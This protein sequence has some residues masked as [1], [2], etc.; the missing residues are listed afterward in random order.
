MENLSIVGASDGHII[1]VSSDGE[2]FQVP[3]N[4][5]LLGALRAPSPGPGVTHR[6]SP[7]DIQAHIRRGLT[8]RQVADLTGEE[9]PYIEKFEGPV[10]AERQFVVDQA[11]AVTVTQKNGPEMTFGTAVR[12][13]LEDI[14]AAEDSWSAWKEESGWQVELLFHEGD[15]EH[16]ARWAFDLRKHLISPVNDDAAVLSRHEPMPTT[17]IPKL[18]AVPSAD[19]PERFDSDIFEASDLGETGPM[20]EPVPYGR[21]GDGPDGDRMADTAD[22]LEVLRR[23]RGERDVVQESEPDT[24]RAGHPSTGGIHLVEDD[25]HTAE[26]TPIGHTS[27][28]DPDDDPEPPPTTKKTRPAMPSWDD[29]VFGA[30]SDD[31]PA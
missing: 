5:A 27:D 26:V 21:Q 4:D 1:L 24:S 6:S 30:R 12:S 16:R 29:I 11:L 9:L 19:R 31:D 22:L 2:R 14:T 10:L 3:I 13:R 28:D 8:A 18:S 17:L 15:V 20:L 23:K 25:S 7:K